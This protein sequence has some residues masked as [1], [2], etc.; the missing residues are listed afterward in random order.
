MSL[1]LDVRGLD[2]EC[3]L[4]LEPEDARFA[5]IERFRFSLRGL[6]RSLSLWLFKWRRSIVKEGRRSDEEEARLGGL[7]QRWR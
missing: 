7:G 1:G 4:S 6:S 5:L 2:L 3:S